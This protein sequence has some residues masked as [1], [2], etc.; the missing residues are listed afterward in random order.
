MSIKVMADN[1][2]VAIRTDASEKIGSGHVMRCLTL[3]HYLKKVGAEVVFACRQYNG[4][5]CDLIES[6]GYQVYRLPAP[7]TGDDEKYTTDHADWLG[8]SQVQDALETSE[9]LANSG[10]GINWLVIDHYALDEQ[11]ER[12]LRP[13][14]K[15]IMV[16][17]DLADRAHDCDILL[18][19]NLYENAA[20][21]YKN[22]V[23]DQCRLLLGPEYSLIREEFLQEQKNIQVRNG[24]ICNILIFYGG[25]DQSN[26]TR[27]AMNAIRLLDLKK[28]TIDVV[29]GAN[30]PNRKAIS[31]ECGKLPN[32]NYYCQVKNIA[33]LMLNADLALG[34]GGTSSWERCCLGLP[35]VITSIAENQN[36]VC[37]NL[38]KRGAAVFLGEKENVSPELITAT[39]QNLFDDPVLLN[40]MSENALKLVDANGAKRVTAEIL[41][42]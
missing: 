26:E 24:R 11:W 25:V 28:L 29:V 35:A 17:D 34:A 41:S 16:I 1:Y 39:L 2:R 7:R 6:E 8:F 15:Q 36:L 14:C 30:N 10:G 31:Q 19:Q 32:F 37:L 33:K 20:T 9:L 12:F 4:N 22:L 38:A 42:H 5:L 18:D 23:Q 27:K 3:A 40:T 13:H 21:R